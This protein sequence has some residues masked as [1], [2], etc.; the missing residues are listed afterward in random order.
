MPSVLVQEVLR[1][2]EDGWSLEDVEWFIDDLRLDDEHAAALWL[3]AWL[4]RRSLETPHP[5]CPQP[6]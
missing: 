5:V 1:R 2:I 6:A 4:D 3:L